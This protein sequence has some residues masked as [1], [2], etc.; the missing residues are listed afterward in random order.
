MHGRSGLCR[1]RERGVHAVP[2][3]AAQRTRRRSA[4]SA[5]STSANATRSPPAVSSAERRA[6]AR[7][8]RAP[9]PHCATKLP[10]NISRL[11]VVFVR[12]ASSRGEAFVQHGER[13]HVDRGAEAV[14]RPPDDSCRAAAATIAASADEVEREARG[15]QV[16][17]VDAAPREP[18]AE[19][20][21][22][23]VAGED[24]RRP[25][26]AGGARRRRAI[27]ALDLHQPRH[28]PQALDRHERAHART[29]RAARSTRS[30]DAR[31]RCAR[32]PTARARPAAS[33]GLRRCRARATQ[34]AER[35]RRASTTARTTNIVAPVRD[36]Q[37]ELERRRRGERAQRRPRP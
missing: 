37:R 11:S 25:S 33:R 27:V 23:E 21:E 31:T 9:M 20:A 7:R 2:P 34:I 5:A 8:R 3:P 32:P 12:P 35:R 17:R 1:G 18:R 26:R 19:E 29:R 4:T 22:R 15:E 6:R 24:R 16:P 13:E 28:R 14:Q 10:P 30:A 36:A